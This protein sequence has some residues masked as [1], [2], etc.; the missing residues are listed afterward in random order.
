MGV[1]QDLIA[2][3]SSEI[4]EH[5]GTRDL[6]LYQLGVELRREFLAGNHF[7]RLYLESLANVLAV[8]LLRTYST[9]GTKM[10]ISFKELTQRKL[11]R[12]TEYINDHLE[13][14]LSLQALAHLVEL[15]PYHFARTFKAVVGLSPH[16]YVTQQ[17]IMQAS[18]LLSKAPRNGS[19]RDAIYRVC[20]F[21]RRKSM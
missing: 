18:R 21:V 4:S 14:E 10:S 2:T 15:S 9:S 13:Q 16:Q 19:R 8:H 12:V 7:N 20:T 11:R 5:Y 3:D 1:A 6:L 17:R